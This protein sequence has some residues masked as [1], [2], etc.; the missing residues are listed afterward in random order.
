M[1]QFFSSF[2]ITI[3]S[4]GRLAVISTGAI[5]ASNSGPSVFC[6]FIIFKVSFFMVVI[7]GEEDKKR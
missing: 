6:F 7:I 2:E 1:V 4:V 5:A 3:G